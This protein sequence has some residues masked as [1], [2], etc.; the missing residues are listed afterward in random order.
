MKNKQKASLI[1][2][3][4]PSAS[5]KLI[6]STNQQRNGEKEKRGGANN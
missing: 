5:G 6:T 3:D 1:S 2:I 4:E